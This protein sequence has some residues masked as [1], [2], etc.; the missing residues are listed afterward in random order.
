MTTVT[1][2]YSSTANAKRG[3]QRAGHKLE[4]VH[5]YPIGDGRFAYKLRTEIQINNKKESQ[6][7]IQN[8][9]DVKMAKRNPKKLERLDDTIE[10]IEK[11]QCLLEQR[12]LELTRSKK[13]DMPAP[14]RRSTDKA[15]PITGVK[16]DKVT[17][18]GVTRPK[19]GGKCAAIWEL[20]DAMQASRGSKRVS[21]AEVREKV[22]GDA[23]RFPPAD[24]H[25]T[26]LSIQFYRWRKHNGITGRE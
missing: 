4:N 22:A 14:A 23:K 8:P 15:G 19:P 3:A 1:A 10:Q 24:W 13:L 26:T 11:T 16:V 7:E 5:V 21:I 25:P 6:G 20:L 9:E 18:F 2:T 17:R 12:K